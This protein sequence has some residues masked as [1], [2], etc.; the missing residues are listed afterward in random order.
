MKNIAIIDKEALSNV[1]FSKQE[2]IPEKTGQ[3][4]RSIDLFRGMVLGNT[5]H[6][7]VRITFKDESEVPHCVETTI[8]AA[9]E[10]YIFL[11]GGKCIP[12]KAI[13]SIDF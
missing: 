11:K 9:L 1:R 6:C 13:T 8:W 2:V 7:K 3:L 10:D 4:K 5:E 12:I